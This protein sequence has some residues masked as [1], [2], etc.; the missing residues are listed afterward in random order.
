MLTNA[1]RFFKSFQPY[2]DLILSF[3]IQNGW[4]FNPQGFASKSG[5]ENSLSTNCTTTIQALS[6]KTSVW[7]FWMTLRPGLVVAGRRSLEQL[8]GL[9]RL[10]SCQFNL[11]QYS[12]QAMDVKQLK[13]IF[14]R[15]TVQIQVEF[16]Q[17]AQRYQFVQK[18]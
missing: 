2:F 16:L 12:F 3:Q 9:L 6:Q 13:I 8:M 10:I 17:T 1:S 7:V 14:F 11:F 18:F 15:G 5:T 4:F